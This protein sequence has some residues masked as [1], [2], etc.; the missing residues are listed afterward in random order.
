[1]KF[2]ANTKLESPNTEK[3]NCH[4][5]E[6][7]SGPVINTASTTN[8]SPAV[9][10]TPNT[11]CDIPPA[12]IKATNITT[13]ISSSVI[14]SGSNTKPAVAVQNANTARESDQ[15]FTGSEESRNKSS[16]AIDSRQSPSVAVNGNT[17]SN[18]GE[19]NLIYTRAPTTVLFICHS[20]RI[21]Q[22]VIVVPE[23]I[24]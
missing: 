4:V 12:Y 11:S 3:A 8:D 5:E 17:H 19:L 13:T 20:A 24:Y 22:A 21:F 9:I 2:N 1:M 15:H 16:V 7:S 23:R 10:T 14:S 6:S 18:P